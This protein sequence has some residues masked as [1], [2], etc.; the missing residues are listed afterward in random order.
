MWLMNL[1]FG[2][3]TVISA[4]KC[5]AENVQ[6]KK[7]VQHLPDGTP[8][9]YDRKGRRYLMNG[10][11]ICGGGGDVLTDPKGNVIWSRTDQWNTEAANKIPAGQYRYC[12][13]YCD[14]SINPVTTNLDTGE[15]IAQIE[16]KIKNGKTECR[17][18]RWYDIYRD[19]Y[20]GRDLTYTC[21]VLPNSVKD[22]DPGIVISEEEFEAIKNC[23]GVRSSIT[24]H[25]CWDD[26]DYY[27]THRR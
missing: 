1:L 6:C 21:K 19:I 10:T 5:G 12:A 24:Y 13:Q 11:P 26:E 9:Y 25:S 18:W 3:A 15:R 14:R 16:R 2:T 17:K 20:P 4:A 7:D 22:G 8:Y 23:P 27:R